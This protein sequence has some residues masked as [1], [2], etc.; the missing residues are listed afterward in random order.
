MGVKWSLGCAVSTMLRH[1]QVAV[2]MHLLVDDGTIIEK[3]MT[4][5][6]NIELDIG[7][8][9]TLSVWIRIDVCFSYYFTSCSASMSEGKVFWIKGY[10]N[11]KI[12]SNT[13][14]QR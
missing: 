12:S 4:K 3:D 5:D 11:I 14:V 2:F 6:E 13:R 10:I 8:F 9:I 1:K 7:N